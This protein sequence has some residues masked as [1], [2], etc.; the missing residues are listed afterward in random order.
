MMHVCTRCHGSLSSSLRLARAA[1]HGLFAAARYHC[2]AAPVTCADGDA[3]GAAS[4]SWHGHPPA[5]EHRA[6][7]DP[8]LQ[9]VPYGEAWVPTVV[10]QEHLLV[11]MVARCL[12]VV[13]QGCLLC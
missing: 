1:L 7:R 2:N 5:K 8:E 11:M 4:T 3:G 6:R 9:K 12:L 10:V 13:E